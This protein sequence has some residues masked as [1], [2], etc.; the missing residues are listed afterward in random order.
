MPRNV[1]LEIRTSCNSCGESIPI[2]GPWTKVTCSACFRE[3]AVPPDILAGFL[4]DFEEEYEG[5]ERG[6]G[7]GG[8]LMSG[9]GTYK[10][11]CWRMP[12]RCANCKKPL[13][14]AGRSGPETVKCPGCGAVYYAFPA[15]DWLKKVVPSA[16][17]CY[18][19]EPPPG[20]IEGT[21]VAP[22]EES[23]KPV[24]MACPSCGGALSVSKGTD[25]IMECRYCSTEVY[26]PDAVWKRLHPVKTTE[27]W[28]AVLDGKTAR[29]LRAERRVRDL[30]EESEEVRRWKLRNTPKQ[31]AV[32]TRPFLRTFGV[33]FAV[34]VAASIFLTIFGNSSESYSFLKLL[35]FAII[36]AA[37]V[38]PVVMAV[39]ST[40]SAQV[41]KGK[42]CKEAMAALAR[43]HGW[44][45]EGA[46]YKTSLGYINDKYRGRDF[47]LDPGDDYAL[48]VDIDDSPFYLSTEPPGYPRDSLR[49]FTTGDPAFDGLFP[50]RYATPELAD[51]IEGSPEGA[52]KVLAPI[53]WFLERWGGKLGRMKIDSSDVAVHLKPGHVEIMDSGGRYLMPGDIE[54]L[55]EDTVA[56]ARAI[57]AVVAGRDPELP[58]PRSA[59]SGTGSPAFDP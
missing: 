46:E 40:C 19:P 30:D 12:P 35:P 21:P 7:S 22:D 33:I 29:Q 42:E 58:D 28:F 11:G 32:K 31:A 49:R 47:E 13:P 14:E 17:C 16:V 20:E 55:L 59:P 6:Q 15:P 50:I 23:E 34:L 26:V 48:E 18:T 27:E 4:N 51:R 1:C 3:T 37:V 2:N 8:T 5:F 10:Y 54:P 45:H 38:I 52:R 24:V 39:R 57:D 56:L 36:A 41:G 53:Y 9:S 25:R 44:T 43:K